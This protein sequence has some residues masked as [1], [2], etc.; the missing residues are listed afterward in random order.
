[1]EEPKKDI[2]ELWGKTH[3][4]FSGSGWAVAKL[5]DQMNKVAGAEEAGL[6][7]KDLNKLM[8]ELFRNVIFRWTP[9]GAEVVM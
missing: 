1:M 8:Q 5:Q 2:D 3:G 4:L 9:S 7:C 6:K